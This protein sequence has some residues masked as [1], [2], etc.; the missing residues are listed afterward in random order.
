MNNLYLNALFGKMNN[1][2][3]NNARLLTPTVKPCFR[4]V[5]KFYDI[6]I[7]IYKFQNKRKNNI[8]VR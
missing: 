7:F 6:E 2:V 1:L 8:I 5:Y 3:N 4:K